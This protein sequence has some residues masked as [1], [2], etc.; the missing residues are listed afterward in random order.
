MGM[1]LKAVHCPWNWAPLCK[2]STR[3]RFCTQQPRPSH[4]FMKKVQ[5]T[6][7]WR[8]D[9]GTVATRDLFFGVV[10]FIFMWLYVFISSLKDDEVSPCLCCFTIFLSADAWIPQ[11]RGSVWPESLW[12]LARRAQKSPQ[13][14]QEEGSEPL[15]HTHPWHTLLKTSLERNHCRGWDVSRDFK[16]GALGAVLISKMSLYKFVQ[17]IIISAGLSGF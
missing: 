3:K 6:L 8:K 7:S 17:V 10:F 5:Q 14:Q 15:R 13:K 2:C 16:S 11:S 1:S 9:L 4:L 12:E